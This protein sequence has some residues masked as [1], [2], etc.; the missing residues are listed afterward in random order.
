MALGAGGGVITYFARHR[1]L[2]NLVLVMLVVAGLVAMTRIRA[3]YFPDVVIAEVSVSVQWPGAGAEDVDRG[4]VQVLEP[5]LLALEGVSDASSQAQEG[6]AWISLAFDPGRNLTQATDDVQAAVDAVRDLPAGVETPVVR[7]TV[8][9][10]QVT[11]VVITGPVSVDQL[12]GFADELVARLFD[13]GV[14]RTT[15]QGLAAPQVVVEVPS[16]ALI[17]HDVTMAEIATAIGAA[18]QTAPAGDVGAGAR[19][20]TGVERRGP[21]QIAAIA[22]RTAA[23]GTQLTIGDLATVRL[24]GVDRA[25]AYFVGDNPAMTVRVD[26]N[27]Q[28]DAIKLQAQVA[29]VAAALQASLPQGVR[30]DLV[31]TRAEQ[32]TDRLALLLDNGLMG[33]GL[34]VALLFLFLNARTALWVAAGIPVSLLAALAAMYVSG[35]TI[36]MISLFALILMTGIVVDDAIVVG[37]HADFRARTLGEPPQLAAENGARRMV[38]PVLASTLTTVIAFG[39]LV[40]VGGRFG[41]MIADIPLVVMFVLMGSTIECFFILPNHMANALRHAGRMHWY[42]VPSHTVM[43]GF[44]WVVARL[45]RPAI[46][47]AITARYVVMALMVLALASQVAVFVRGEVQFRFFSG[48]EQTTVTGNFALLPGASRD[49]TMAMMRELQRATAAVGERYE[50][51]YGS[52]PFTFVQAVV[53]GGA[54]R[55]LAGA[56][57]RDPDLLGGISIELID[58]DLRS[59]PSSTFV[60]DL[61]DEVRP[62]TLL[63]E[64]SFRGGHFGPG[65]NAL[66]VDLYGADAEILKAAAEAVK[67]ALAPFPEVSGLEDTLAYDKQEMILNLTPQGRALGFASDALGRELRDRLNGIEA[68]SFPDGPRSATIRVELPAGE[69]AAD[70]LDRTVMRASGG[71]YVPL[72]DIVAAE[73]RSGFATIDRENGLRLVTVSGDLAEDDPARAAEVQRLLAENIVPRIEADFGVSARLSGLNQQQDAFLSDAGIALLLALLGIYLTLAWIFGRWLRPLVVMAVIPFGLVGVIWGHAW[74]G[75][76]LS[77]FS[78]VGMIGMTGIIINDAIVL[79]STIDQYAADRGLRAAII[80]GVADRLRPVLLTTLTTVLGLAP[81]LYETSRQ[82]EFLRPTVITLVY[83]LGFG[84]V[85]VLLLV[86]AVL[87]LEADVARQMVALRRMLRGGPKVARDIVLATAAALAGLFAATLGRVLLAGDLPGWLAALVPVGTDAAASGVALTL[88]VA[89]VVAISLLA[90]AFGWLVLRPRR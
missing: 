79:I 15:I 43:R 71:Q 53:G 55:G 3:Q 27:D 65:G 35:M 25:R 44:D 61:Q 49:D 31:R 9:R 17:R 57:T 39:A 87:A 5:A 88:F 50:A 47:W 89:G 66:S 62:Q 14:T 4:I 28:G 82:A 13:V 12:G 52:A 21:D 54:G 42:D 60:A 2:A 67:T 23:D 22:L 6:S 7:R 77:L 81:L 19:V 20:R 70:F 75:V 30:V 11:D 85:L 29:E 36:N 83:G 69:L 64:L 26:R 38:A 56:E 37:E 1:T 33:L 76:P 80:D 90:W 63:E 72:G 18:V 68:A 46:G 10:D 32:I 34:V 58:R 16:V 59:W 45:V 51:E 73:Q 40:L 86:P 74:W 48:P 78:V 8:W 84:M 41:D 24:E